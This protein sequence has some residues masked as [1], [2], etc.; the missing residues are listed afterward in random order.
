MRS[1]WTAAVSA[2]L[3]IVASTAFSPT[4]DA[5]ASW[6]PPTTLGQAGRESGAPELAV[7]PDG[8]A[9]ATWVGS[10]PNGIRVSRRRPGK[11]WSPPI[12]IAA[13]REVEGPQI[14]VSAGKAVIVWMDT[15]ETRFGEARVIFAASSLRGQRWSRP[16]NISAEKRWR[17]EPD[18]AEP[19]VAITPAGKAIVVWSANNEGHSTVSFIASATQAAAGTRWTAPVGIPGSFEG[20]APQVAITPEG[21]AVAIWG[22]SYNEESTI[23]VSSRPANGPWKGAWW[24]ATPGPFPQPLLAL[25]SKG[26]AIGAWVK[27]P[28]GGL[29]ATVQV[30]TRTPGGKWRVKS[31][32]PKDYGVVPQIVTEPG[33]RATVFWAKITSPDE[34]TV[35][36]STH[37]PGAGW[38]K[39][40]SVANQGLQLTFVSESPIAVT[41][42]GE[43]I[44]IWM[45]DT[46]PEEPTTVLSSSRRRG[47]PWTAPTAISTSPVGPLYGASDLR[48]AI[49]PSGEAVAV[50]RSFNGT[51]WVIRSATRRAAGS[52]S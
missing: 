24:L 11:G 8:E 44:A 9:I 12:T 49:A 7:A 46:S 21:E 35:V 4:A 17:S 23:A 1:G 41:P 15:I 52:E 32:A 50:W 5:A 25:T 29:E 48:L 13:A 18:G 31:L 43:S 22:A 14:A 34:A 2:A 20:E 27:E 33:G 39:P 42:Q 6:R 10:R 28:E 36:A 51:R 47:Q 45:A 19:Q 26:E 40:V 38:R 30:T 16:R 37:V 3:L